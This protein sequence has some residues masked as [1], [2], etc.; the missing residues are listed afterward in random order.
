MRPP[1]AQEL[2]EN[3]RQF[4]SDYFPSFAGHYV[5]AGGGA[6]VGVALLLFPDAYQ[7]V[8]V[9]G[10]WLV[11]LL[12]VIAGYLAWLDERRRADGEHKKVLALEERMKPRITVSC[13]DEQCVLPPHALGGNALFRVATHLGG[14]DLVTNVVAKI[15]AIRK[16]GHKLPLLEPVRL[17]FHS[18]NDGSGELKTMRPETSEPLDM[19]AIVNGELWLSLAWGY[20]AFD[21]R[22]CNDP[23]HTYE[24]DVAISSSIWPTDFT[25]VCHWTGDFDT[26]KPYIKQQP[27]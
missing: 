14:A 8:R 4:F 21:N 26:T 23:N 20:G 27:L 16:D 3:C 19:L 10:F 15:K 13:D 24:I 11:V 1:T 2:R 17:K 18:S 22:C 5:Y 7:G 9:S 6:I 25:Y 12:F